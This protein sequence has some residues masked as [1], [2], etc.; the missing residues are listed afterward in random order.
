MVSD[1]EIMCK[2]RS[3]YSPTTSTR[4]SCV[5]SRA[6]ESNDKTSKDVEGKSKGGDKRRHVEPLIS[7]SDGEHGKDKEV[8]H[9]D[10]STVSDSIPLMRQDALESW[11]GPDL[12]VSGPFSSAKES[13]LSG[14]ANLS[15][16]TVDRELRKYTLLDFT[17]GDGMDVMYA[18]SNEQSSYSP[19]MVCILYN[20]S[21]DAIFNIVVK[22]DESIESPAEPGAP[23]TEVHDQPVV[24]SE[25]PKVIPMQEIP[26]LGPGQTIEAELVPLKLG[27]Y[28]NSNEIKER[29]LLANGDLKKIKAIFFLHCYSS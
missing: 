1:L 3:R 12:P 7:L 10:L 2:D 13:T 5:K 14:Y 9:H 22:A 6:S 20:R 25:P 29:N 28:S 15:I 11:L 18:F 21:S 4:N 16:G 19:M 17:N 27:V 8:D 24:S 23:T 26:C